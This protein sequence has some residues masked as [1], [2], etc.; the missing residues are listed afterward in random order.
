M[1]RE[2]DPALVMR[3]DLQAF[4]LGFPEQGL[5]AGGEHAMLRG[6][7]ATFRWAQ[8]EELIPLDPFK[9]LKMP[10]R[11]KEKPPTVQPDEV[12]AMLTA[13]R[14]GPQVLRDGAVL[15]VLF[16]MGLRMGN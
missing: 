3:D 11:P 15:I 2:D 8:E 4:Q 5:G 6:L 9:K 7:R 14:A 10:I 12:A 1:G 16:D 13:A